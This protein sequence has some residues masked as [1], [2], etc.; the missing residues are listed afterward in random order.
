M[1]LPPAWVS[2]DK[3]GSGDVNVRVLFEERLVNA[4]KF[5]GADVLVVNRAAHFVLLGEGKGADGNQQ[6]AIGHKAVIE[7]GRG[8]GRPEEAAERGQSERRAASVG[9]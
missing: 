5:F 4:A 2:E 8:A 7:V 3:F 6:V 1:R 9:A